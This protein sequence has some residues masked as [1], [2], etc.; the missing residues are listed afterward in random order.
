MCQVIWLCPWMSLSAMLYSSMFCLTMLG[1]PASG[2]WMTKP[3]GRRALAIFVG[4]LL[5]HLLLLFLLLEGCGFVHCTCVLLHLAQARFLGPRARLVR[6]PCAPPQPNN[7]ALPR[8]RPTGV[9][10]HPFA[11][12]SPIALR[13]SRPSP[14]SRCRFSR[15][16][17]RSGRIL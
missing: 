5:L 9:S 11:S 13:R 1:A 2:T 16:A 14:T 12:L 15:T 7:S 17:M 8:Q 10:K 6:E 3:Y 4:L